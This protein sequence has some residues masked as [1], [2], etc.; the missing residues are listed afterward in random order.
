MKAAWRPMVA[1]EGSTFS[2]VMVIGLK[3]GPH[4]LTKRKPFQGP[5]GMM[6]RE[7]ISDVLK[8]AYMTNLIKVDPNG[9]S[10]AECIKHGNIA[11]EV[12]RVQPKVVVS[13]GGETTS[14]ILGQK[15]PIRRIHGLVIPT[16]RFGHQ[17]LVLPIYDPGFVIRSGGLL[18][19]KGVEW[20]QDWNELRRIDGLRDISTNLQSAASK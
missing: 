11:Q 17:F 20:V 5:A 6:V 19:E 3:P 7:A 4:E 14:Y 15:H 1:P 9:K 12:N 8:K 13:V 2:E 18:S 16:E 10:V